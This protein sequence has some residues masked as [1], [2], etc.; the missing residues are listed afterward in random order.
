MLRRSCTRAALRTVSASAIAPRAAP[1]AAVPAAAP[2]CSLVARRHCAASKEVA[3]EPGCWCMPANNFDAFRYGVAA[4]IAFFLLADG[5]FCRRWFGPL[6]GR[7]EKKPN[8]KP[9]GAKIDGIVFS[10]PSGVGKGTVIKQIM[11]EAPGVYDFCVS[12]TTRA[13]RAGEKD[14]VHYHFTT[15]AA[16]QAMV[17]RGEFLESCDVHGN[18]YGTSKA[19]LKAV[20]DSGKLP[21]VEIDYKG[22]QK[23]QKAD[24]AKDLELYYVFIQAPS[25]AELESRIVGRGQETPEKVQR[26]LVTARDEMAFIASKPETYDKV[27]TNDDLGRA[28]DQVQRLLQVYGGVPAP[29]LRYA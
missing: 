9:H 8:T 3:A 14:G 21:I 1:L 26:R 13:P 19:A 29:G 25:L 20:H 18:M 6:V 27:V 28:V 22:V 5:S 2:S 15:R 24:G 12:H 17:A 7:G 4:I 11:S 10:G 16:M 23:L